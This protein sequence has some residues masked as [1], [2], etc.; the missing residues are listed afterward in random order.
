LIGELAVGDVIAVRTSGWAADVIRFAEALG[1]KS[2]LASHVAIVHHRDIR[3]R[4]WGIEGRPGGVGWVDMAKYT[5]G[6]FAKF[7][8][9]NA[10]QPRTEAQRVTI[11][12]VASG[13]LGVG[14]D[15]AGGIFADGLD[16]MHLGSLAVLLD[17]WWG[18]AD[19]SHQAPGHLVC[20]SAAAWVYRS[21]G[22][23]RPAGTSERIQPSDWWDWNTAA[24]WET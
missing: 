5:R 3:K 13:L 20:S 2:N 21:L 8:N 4:W 7:G 10:A 15:W 24:G 22:L 6:P 12:T 17:L 1:G 16:D 14:Y 23:P 11:A 19:K 9:S 18:W